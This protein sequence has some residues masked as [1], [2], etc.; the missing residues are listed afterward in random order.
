MGDI[1][2]GSSYKNDFSC[3]QGGG[4]VPPEM[5]WTNAAEIAWAGST[6]LAAIKVREVK[7]RI[8]C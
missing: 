6:V 1:E 2:K 8:I 7:S 5:L 4:S 3:Y